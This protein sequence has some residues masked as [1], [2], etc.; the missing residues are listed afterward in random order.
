LHKVLSSGLGKAGW[1]A[2]VLVPTRELVEQVRGEAVALAAAC[3]AELT[4]TAIA[5]E[6]AARTAVATAVRIALFIL[7]QF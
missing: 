7:L 5:G 1:Q 4:V 3:G 6:G 2:L